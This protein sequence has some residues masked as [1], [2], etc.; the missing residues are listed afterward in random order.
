MI[1]EAPHA[2]AGARD[3]DRARG[4]H[5]PPRLER[6]DRERSGVA[7]GPDDHRVCASRTPPG[8]ATSH[9]AVDP[10]LLASPPHR[11]SPT[12]QPFSTTV[13]PAFH[14]GELLSTTVPAKSMPGTIGKL[15]TTGLP[16]TIASASL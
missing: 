11:S 12:P 10:G 1:G 15:R 8:V 13:S 3:D 2:A 4:G 7:G 5:H 9:D 6:T 14:T 16:F